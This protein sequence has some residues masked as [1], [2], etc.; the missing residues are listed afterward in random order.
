MTTDEKVELASQ[1]ATELKSWWEESKKEES[2]RWG[3]R[4][5]RDDLKF[6]K[7]EWQRWASYFRGVQDLTRALRLAEHQ[8]RSPALRA[9]PKAAAQAIHK[10]L[11]RRRAE[12]Q[13]IPTEDLDE[14]F[15]YVSRW[16]EWL[17]HLGG[18]HEK[19][20][21]GHAGRDPG[22]RYRGR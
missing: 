17:N 22:R 20:S 1:L 21:P 19:S 13:M 4:L 18:R 9:H 14:I 15:G 11:S 2:R 5:R 6:P 3:R 7:N 12:L 16:L 10:V 8:G